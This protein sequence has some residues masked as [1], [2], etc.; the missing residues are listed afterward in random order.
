MN[1]LPPEKRDKPYLIIGTK[2][3]TPS[4]LKKEVE[5]DTEIGKMVSKTLDKGRL[6]ML[7]R[8]R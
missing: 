3:F 8:K 7:K 6:E 4:E 1:K 5:N 2:S